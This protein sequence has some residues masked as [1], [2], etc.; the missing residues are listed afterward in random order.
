MSGMSRRYQTDFLTKDE[1]SCLL[2]EYLCF[3]SHENRVKFATKFAE[4]LDNNVITMTAAVFKSLLNL[5]LDSRSNFKKFLSEV[6][7]GKIRLI[8]PPLNFGPKL[9]NKH[10]LE[11][12]GL[13]EMPDYDLFI[14]AGGGDI[15]KKYIIYFYVYRYQNKTD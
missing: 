4:T 10:N 12:V 5:K 1:K 8:V 13:T 14:K 9:L 11:L 7:E 3:L 2:E 6:K 15:I